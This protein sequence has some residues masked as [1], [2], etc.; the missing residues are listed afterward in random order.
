VA[1]TLSSSRPSEQAAP[2]QLWPELRGIRPAADEQEMARKDV[3]VSGAFGG[4]VAEAAAPAVTVASMAIEGDT[5]VYNY[6]EAVTVATGSENL[7][8][9]LD[10]LDFAPVVK[11]VAVPRIDRT[12]FV[13]ASFTNAS[14]EPLLPGQAMLFR[15]G[16]LVG[17]TWLDVIAPGG[18]AEGGLCA[19]GPLRDQREMPVRARGQPGVFPSAHP[20][21]DSAGSTGRHDRPRGAAG[22]RAVRPD[23]HDRRPRWTQARDRVVHRRDPREDRRGGSTW[24]SLAHRGAP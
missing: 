9:A 5:V 20:Q 1:L 7:R 23:R 13:M 11:A 4:V 17:S 19:N 18:G 16:V 12:A 6:P 15:E 10:S 3:M 21:S 14:E 8:L 22:H 24:R 2:S